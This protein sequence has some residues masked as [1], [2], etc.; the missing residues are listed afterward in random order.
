VRPHFRN[1]ST[2]A[3]AV[4]ATPVL[5]ALPHLLLVACHTTLPSVACCPLAL[6]SPADAAA[7]LLPLLPMAMAFFA[8][9]SQSAA[10]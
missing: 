2:A 6:S 7:P 1:S 5:L 10:R 4:A 3:T 8:C 9:L